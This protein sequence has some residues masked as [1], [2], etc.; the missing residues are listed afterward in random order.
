MKFQWQ[1]YFQYQALFLDH[2]FYLFNLLL[3][4][5]YELK[6]YITFQT[7]IRVAQLQLST[8]C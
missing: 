4:S 2:N 1:I 8:L 5:K 3:L 7:I 6:M